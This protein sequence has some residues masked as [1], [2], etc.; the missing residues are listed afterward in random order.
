MKFNFLLPIKKQ[1][2][3]GLFLGRNII[4]HQ[5]VYLCRHR[6]SI[7]SMRNRRR[8]EPLQTERYQNNVRMLDGKT[9]REILA[10]LCW[11]YACA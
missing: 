4:T 3:V 8:E 10:S 9:R 11:P 5:G 7:Q 1:L 6:L 2:H